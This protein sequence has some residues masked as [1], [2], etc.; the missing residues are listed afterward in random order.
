METLGK[1]SGPTPSLHFLANADL[2]K[3]VL[4]IK[5]SGKTSEQCKEECKKCQIYLI[6]RLYDFD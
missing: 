3:T 5:R 6:R 2:W 4:K 1:N